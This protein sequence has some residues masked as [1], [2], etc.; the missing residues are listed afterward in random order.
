MIRRPEK[1]NNFATNN[2][3]TGNF[4]TNNFKKSRY[5]SDYIQSLQRKVLYTEPIFLTDVKFK[6]S[7]EKTGASAITSAS[8]DTSS[9]TNAN[10]NVNDT[11]RFEVVTSSSSRWKYDKFAF[12]NIAKFSSSN[13][14]SKRAVSQILR[15]ILLERKITLQAIGQEHSM[16]EKITNVCKQISAAFVGKF[17][18][19]AFEIDMFLK[20]EKTES[21]NVL[22]IDFDTSNEQESNVAAMLKYLY[23]GQTGKLTFNSQQSVVNFM[24]ARRY[25][26]KANCILTFMSG[27]I[28]VYGL[29]FT[30][31]D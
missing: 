1:M 16:V 17:E 13:I 15:Q 12:G 30:S 2:N 28:P 11:H 7:T 24:K 3:T 22:V 27:V 9:N 14:Q 10:A 4:A 18:T 23:L 25:Q 26:L 31:H 6:S 21:P 8:T 5:L 20:L 19:L 29:L